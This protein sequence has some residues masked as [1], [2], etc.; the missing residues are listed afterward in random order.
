[1]FNDGS[2]YLVRR[3]SAQE[4]EGGDG[5]PSLSEEDGGAGGSDDGRGT[6]PFFFLSRPARADQRQSVRERAAVAA[7]RIRGLLGDA[8]LA[9]EVDAEM[10]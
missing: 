2:L 4:E 10:T 7:E 5:S 9:A 8:G 6:R 3:L 1:M